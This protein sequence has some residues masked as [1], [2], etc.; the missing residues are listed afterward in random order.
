MSEFPSREVVE[1]FD[2]REDDAATGSE[3]PEP[4]SL[5]QPRIAGP[6]ALPAGESN[7]GEFN[8][9]AILLCQAFV[10]KMDLHWWTS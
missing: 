1:G 9:G 4:I 2:D 5:S 3:R 7:K 8:E 6:V 10:W